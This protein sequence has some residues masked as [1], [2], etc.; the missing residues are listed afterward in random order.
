VVSKAQ[1]MALAAGDAWLNNGANLL[2]FGPPGG[3]KSHLAAALG[4]ALGENGSRVLFYPHHRSRPTAASCPPRARSRSHHCQARQIPSPDP[5][6]PPYVTKDQAETSA[7]R[8]DHRACCGAAL[9]RAEPAA[10]LVL[11]LWEEAD[12]F[13]RVADPHDTF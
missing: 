6:R 5:R 3:G 12:V 2:L 13:C 7:N 10:E 11:R 1:V 4:F 8:R 9:A